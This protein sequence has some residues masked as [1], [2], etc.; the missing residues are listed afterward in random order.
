MSRASGR[1]FKK[2]LTKLNVDSS[3]FSEQLKQGLVSVDDEGNLIMVPVLQMGPNQ[4]LT[5]SK[6]KSCDIPAAVGTA[7][8]WLPDR[9]KRVRVM[10]GM[11]TMGGVAAAL[12]VR[13]L[14]VEQSG[15]IAIP[16][17]NIRMHLT[18][19]TA[20]ASAVS[21]YFDLRPNGILLDVNASV[22]VITAGTDY[23]TGQDTVTVWGTE[24]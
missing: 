2:V 19:N 15:A 16:K 8:I 3:Y 7:V 10:G 18:V 14:S 5:S 21:G 17:L 1:P 20:V 22:N 9:G 13:T 6:T 23:T 24:E 4:N 11:I 12:G